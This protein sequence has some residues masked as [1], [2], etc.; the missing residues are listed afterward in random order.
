MDGTVIVWLDTGKPLAEGPD[1]PW[2][3]SATDTHHD[4]LHGR[5]SVRAY[6]T[7]QAKPFVALRAHLHRVDTSGNERHTH[8]NLAQSASLLATDYGR[9]LDPGTMAADPFFALHD[10]FT[11][12]AFSYR[13]YLNLLEQKS[14]KR[15]QLALDADNGRHKHSNLSQWDSTNILYDRTI[16][17]EHM[18]HLRALLDIVRNRGPRVGML[19]ANHCWPRSSNPQQE[20]RATDA[21]RQLLGYF[22]DL[23]SQ[24][25][26]L[27]VRYSEGMSVLMNRAI[28]AEANKNLEQAKEVAKLTKL[29]F[30]YIPLSF[31]ATFFGMNVSPIN[32]SQ[33]NLLHLWVWFVV[34]APVLIVSLILMIW[35][36]RDICEWCKGLALRLWTLQAR[37]FV[38]GEKSSDASTPPDYD[39]DVMVEP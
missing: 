31:T 38:G 12:I 13:Q 2:Q 24:A 3:S 33:N 22:E 26:R 36:V 15:S 32:G 9:F 10:I 5:S 4:A 18:T 16:L 25:G 21:A 14:T 8:D 27:L 30:V 29:A 34:S 19:N 11:F 23:E 1:G 7:I 20:Q 35:D 17:E 28:V 37:R 39:E 6:P